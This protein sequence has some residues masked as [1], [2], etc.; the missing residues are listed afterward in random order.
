MTSALLHQRLCSLLQK[1]TTPLYIALSGGIDSITLMTVAARVRT[2]PVIAL[3]AVSAAV[4]EL[5]TRRCRELAKK[6]DWQ[7]TEI[8]AREFDNQDYIANPVNRCYYCK[9]SLFD[10]MLQ[11]DNS[12]TLHELSDTSIA[13]GTN[14]DDLGDYRPGLLA[15]REHNVWQPYVEAGIDKKTIRVI[16]ALEGLGDLAELPAQPCL[17]SRVETGIAINADDLRFIEKVE[18]AITSMT[19]AGDIRCRLTVSGVAV[20]LPADNPIL[21]AGSTRENAMSMVEKLCLAQQRH[22]IGF[23]PYKMGSAFLK[24]TI[25]IQPDV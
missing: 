9:S 22:F 3:H 2:Q 24:Q 19:Q 21:K 23:Q 11:F 14:T 17:S 15:A 7:L 25:A 16:A 13:T 5:A 6:F 12:T 18:S 8:D 10:R 4:P 1:Q 20:Q